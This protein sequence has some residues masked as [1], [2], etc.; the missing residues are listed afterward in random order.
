MTFGIAITGPA[1]R[2]GVDST[3]EAVERAAACG[4]DGIEFWGLADADLEAVRAA[5]EDYGIDV[6]GSGAMGA[7]SCIGDVDAPCMVRPEYHDQAVADIEASLERVAAFDG[8]SLLLTVG[9]RQPDLDES[10]QQNAIVDVLRAIAPTAES[11]GIT[12]VTELLN[13]RIDHPNYFLQTTDQGAA[14]VN[15]VDSSNVKMLFD[16]Y[17]QQITE[18]D[19]IRRFRRHVD[20]IGHVHFADNPG[21]NEPGTGELNYERIFAA[22]A[23]SEYNDYV[24]AEFTPTGDPDEIFAD[25]VE[26]ADQVR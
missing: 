6:F 8:S 23:E 7:G 24:S 4:F 10:T 17:H 9:Q 20:Q 25:V 5:G 1:G 15:A 14:I 2:F 26:L 3:A 12:V 16:I 18:G 21:R 19:V 22:I 13:G 11:H